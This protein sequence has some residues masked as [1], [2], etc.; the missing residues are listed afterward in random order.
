M[1]YHKAHLLKATRFRRLTGVQKG[2]FAKLVEVLIAA[3]KQEHSKHGGRTPKLSLE[4]RL[5][6]G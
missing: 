1:L 4:D 6:T 2:T 3:Q 5:L